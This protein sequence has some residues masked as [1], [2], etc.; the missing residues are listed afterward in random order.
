MDHNK[1][2]MDIVCSHKIIA[3]VRAIGVCSSIDGLSMH[4]LLRQGVTPQHFFRKAGVSTDQDSPIYSKIEPHGASI[5]F[6]VPPIVSSPDDIDW[7]A[8]DIPAVR[9][10]KTKRPTRQICITPK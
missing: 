8:Q 6:G 3:C 9:K 5:N 1:E 10:S 2:F 4:Y 7:L